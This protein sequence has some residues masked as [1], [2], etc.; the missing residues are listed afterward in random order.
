MCFEYGT[1]GHFGN[2]GLFKNH[3]ITGARVIFAVEKGPIYHYL[4]PKHLFYQDNQ[5]KFLLMQQLF[6]SLFIQEWEK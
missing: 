2:F 1:P 5:S 4:S 3:T 6:D